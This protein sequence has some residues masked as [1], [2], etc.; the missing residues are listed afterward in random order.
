MPPFKP[1]PESPPFV[2][3]KIV[4]MTDGG[5]APVPPGYSVERVVEI[6]RETGHEP[7]AIHDLQMN[8][9]LMLEDRA[10]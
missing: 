10:A 1:K 9:L 6:L 8:D 5:Q 7:E 4:L 2:P 3:E